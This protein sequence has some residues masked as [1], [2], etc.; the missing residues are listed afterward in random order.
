MT[1]IANDLVDLSVIDAFSLRV[2]NSKGGYDP[3]AT[4]YD[5]VYALAHAR[6]IGAKVVNLS[7]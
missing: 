6:D 4:L 7:L 5:I 3:N 2:A 1:K